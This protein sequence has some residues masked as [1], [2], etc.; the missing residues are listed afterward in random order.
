[1]LAA[2]NDANGII[3]CP[4]KERAMTFLLSPARVSVLLVLLKMLSIDSFVSPGSRSHHLQLDE[5]TRLGATRRD[6]LFS[7]SA[8]VVVGLP[9]AAQAGI[10]PSA[11]RNLPVEGDP[12]GTAMRLRQIEAGKG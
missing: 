1:M 10:D 8:S 4:S 2:L 12:S 9:K 5:I 6:M 7:V 11:L 3:I